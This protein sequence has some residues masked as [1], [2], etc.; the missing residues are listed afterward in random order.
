MG[1]GGGIV[2]PVVSARVRSTEPVAP[3]V[4]GECTARREG[5]WAEEL[6]AVSYQLLAKAGEPTDL[7][8]G[9]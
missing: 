7:P 1:S 8:G 5:G 6:L 9:G 4:D 3:D 2:I